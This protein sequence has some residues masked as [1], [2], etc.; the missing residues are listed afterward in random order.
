MSNHLAQGE[1]KSNYWDV[2]K[3]ERK[4]KSVKSKTP[5]DK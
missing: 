4:K 2:T 3:K 1:K 5:K